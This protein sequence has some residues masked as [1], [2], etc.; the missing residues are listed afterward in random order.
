M[1]TKASD[2]LS[3]GKDPKFLCGVAVSV[4]Q[5]S[6]A[7]PS[8]C[9]HDLFAFEANAVCPS[10]MI[11]IVSLCYIGCH[12]A[13]LCHNGTILIRQDLPWTFQL[14]W[15]PTVKLLLLMVDLDEQGTPMPSG[16]TSRNRSKRTSIYAC[17][18]LLAR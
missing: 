1:G 15:W 3:L 4:Y 2:S 16:R 5:N 9:P 14:L 17:A 18:S 8:P 10:G 7:A 6:G 13:L 12:L 11:A